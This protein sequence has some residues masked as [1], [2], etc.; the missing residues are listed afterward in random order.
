MA[1][2]YEEART[3]DAQLSAANP[4]FLIREAL[5]GS[6]VK[7]ESDVDFADPHAPTYVIKGHERSKVLAV[8][9]YPDLKRG[10][11]STE[12]VALPETLR[13]CKA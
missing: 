10:N 2:T 3:L 6:S 13:V 11:L 1:L 5:V 9:I 12:D 7:T 8:A 4:S